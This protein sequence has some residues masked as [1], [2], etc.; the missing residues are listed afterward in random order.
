LQTVASYSYILLIIIIERNPSRQP[1]IFSLELS[2][3]RGRRRR[4]SRS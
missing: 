1:F 2:R 4:S 3:R